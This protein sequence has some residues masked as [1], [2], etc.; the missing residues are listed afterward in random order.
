MKIFV[1]VIFRKEKEKI[2]RRKD[3]IYEVF[4]ASPPKNG[5]ANREA[6]GILATFFNKKIEDIKIVSGKTGRNKIVIIKEN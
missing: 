6:K 2:R 1:K 5:R 3:G 4:I